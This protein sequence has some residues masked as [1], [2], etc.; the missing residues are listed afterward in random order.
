[1]I[2]RSADYGSN[3][4]I[5]LD[6]AWMATHGLTTK[7]VAECMNVSPNT[8]SQPIRGTL[9]DISAGGACVIAEWPVEPQSVLAWR[10]HFPSVPVPVPV[11]MQVRGVQPL[12]RIGSF[13]IALAF[14]T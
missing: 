5:R 10:F 13:R 11:L 4:Q 9:V 2:V 7:D 14:I 12:P 6:G 1:M 3:G 8:V